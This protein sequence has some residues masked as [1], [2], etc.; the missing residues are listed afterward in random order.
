MNYNEIEDIK[1]KV[2]EIRKETLEKKEMR[3]RIINEKENM[4]INIYKLNILNKIAKEE[5]GGISPYYYDRLE[6]LKCDFESIEI[7][8]KELGCEENKL[9]KIIRDTKKAKIEVQT[10]QS[11][12]IAPM[13]RLARNTSRSKRIKNYY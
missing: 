13:P 8:I 1:L 6:E 11:R 3:K 7:Q 4:E 2:E 5:I 10:N 12:A 9:N